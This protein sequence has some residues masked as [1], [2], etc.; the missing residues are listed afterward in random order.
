MGYVTAAD[1]NTVSLSA[2]RSILAGPTE[3][4]AEWTRAAA[5]HGVTEAQAVYG[6]MLLEGR[7]VD[8]DPAE[9]VRW[10]SRAARHDHPMAMNMLGRCYDN[11]WGVSPSETLA[12]YWYR[13]AAEQGLDWGMYNYATLLTIGKQIPTDRRAAFEWFNKAAQIGHAKSLNIVGGFHEDGWEV[14]QDPVTA[15]DYYRRA[16]LGGDFRGQF[17]LARLLGNAGHIEEALNW[18]NRVPETATP[19]FMTKM[20]TF[21]SQSAI[22]EFRT[23]AHRLR[24]SQPV[25]QA[26]TG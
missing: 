11:G 9:A 25:V 23:Y 22:A 26:Q 5:E 15:I 8:R 6:Q 1:L 12:A 19:A 13:L 17:N 7:G 10:F 20:I 21:L 18:L 2:M 3:N 16:A 24:K 4:A 14:V